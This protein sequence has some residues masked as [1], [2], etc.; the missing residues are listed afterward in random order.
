M[1]SGANQSRRRLNQYQQPEAAPAVSEPIE[2]TPEPVAAKPRRPDPE[3]LVE[4]IEVRAANDPVKANFFTLPPSKLMIYAER[5]SAELRHV[6]EQKGLYTAIQGKNYVHVGGWSVMGAMLGITV[7]EVDERIFEL[8]DG[9][10]QAT[11]VLIRDADGRQISKASS[12]CGIDEDRWKT[13][14]RYARRSMAITRATGKAYRLNFSWIMSMA[15]Y[16]PTP[17]EEMPGYGG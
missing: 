15:G 12:I 1:Y 3:T 6:V 2:V 4:A 10:W 7:E 8:P 5:V 17:A 11:V 14:P 16:Q 9:S 13:A